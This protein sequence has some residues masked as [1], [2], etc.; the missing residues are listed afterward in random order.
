MAKQSRDFK[1]PR[2]SDKERG[3]MLY[4]SSVH[5]GVAEHLVFSLN[6]PINTTTGFS[7]LRLILDSAHLSDP[8]LLNVFMD[9]I[10]HFISGHKVCSYQIGGFLV[11]QSP[12]RSVGFTPSTLRLKYTLLSSTYYHSKKDISFFLSPFHK[13][14]FGIYFYSMPDSVNLETTAEQGKGCM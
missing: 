10:Y 7:K 3:V 2:S 1:L 8:D 4:W 12:R 14:E 13:T 11:D 6:R 5:S 9:H